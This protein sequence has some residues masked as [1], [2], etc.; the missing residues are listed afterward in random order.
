MCLCVVAVVTEKLRQND[1][2][3]AAVLEERQGLIAEILNVNAHDVSDKVQVSAQNLCSVLVH[4]GRLCR[5][6]K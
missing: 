6:K 4:L 1:E 2:N 5:K 3:L